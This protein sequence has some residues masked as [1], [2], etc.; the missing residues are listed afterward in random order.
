MREGRC[1]LYVAHLPPSPL[2]STTPAHP[3]DST[4]PITTE[5]LGV[6]VIK[7]AVGDMVVGWRLVG[8]AVGVAV[9]GDVQVMV[10][11]VVGELV[12][13]DLFVPLRVANSCRVLK[14]SGVLLVIARSSSRMAC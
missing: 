1:S 2:L 11:D 9:I 13:K 4:C 5:P 12:I 7:G 8:P 3:H 10:W 6:T 14:C